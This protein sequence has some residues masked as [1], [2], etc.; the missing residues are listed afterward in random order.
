MKKIYI[1][2][3]IFMFIT[4]AFATAYS[5]DV[6]LVTC[7]PNW[8]CTNFSQATC[9]T[10]SCSDI[11]ACGYNI[12]KPTEYIACPQKSGGSGSDEGAA[13]VYG[14]SITS[15]DFTLSND[16]LKLEVKQGDVAQKIISINSK[17]DLQY[18]ISMV[19][20]KGYTEKQNLITLGKT[21]LTT[22]NG[23]GDFN[24]II[25]S[26][27]TS[28]GTYVSVI[29]VSNRDISRNITL[30]LDVIDKNPK[31][32]LAIDINTMPTEIVVKNQ[33]N[34][35]IHTDNA[36][37]GAV[38]LTTSIIDPLGNTLYYKSDIVSNINDY[39]YETGIDKSIGEGY[40]TLFVKIVDSNNNN[41]TKSKVFTALNP[42][43]YFPMTERPS[44]IEYGTQLIVWI[45]IG[46]ILLI[47]VLSNIY[48]YSMLNGNNPISGM[49]SAKPEFK[50]ST[51]KLPPNI[52]I[53]KGLYNR[54]FIKKREYDK[55]L[56]DSGYTTANSVLNVKEN[57]RKIEVVAA[58]IETF[59]EKTYNN[60]VEVRAP[61]EKAFVLK[62][63]DRLYSIKDLSE[64][65]KKMPDDVFTHHTTGRNDFANWISGVFNKKELAENISKAKNIEEM[66]KIL[67]G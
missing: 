64:Y 34:Y 45:S 66:R 35:T 55:I 27:N 50:T 63:G 8:Y 13:Q 62:N 38:N 48:I 44:G 1:L 20:Q 58:K 57:I 23:A 26:T 47:L 42:N 54:G 18:G 12:G 28:I 53:A 40:Y 2:T 41:F 3:I 5:F 4:L 49:D 25:D 61:E 39:N 24:I 37:I 43:K 30:V 52:K 22:Q 29:T 60:I 65:L 59:V 10:R 16:L 56:E 6:N 7:N 19:Y 46:V 31:V 51:R 36:I 33:L 21:T 9:G 11:N 32:N 67:E 15:H 17:Y 14:E